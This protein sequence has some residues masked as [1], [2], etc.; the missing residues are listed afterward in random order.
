MAVI[1]ITDGG[2]IHRTDCVIW[3]P[4][5]LPIIRGYHT[6]VDCQSDLRRAGKEVTICPG[7][8]ASDAAC[9]A[10]RISDLRGALDALLAIP[11]D[12][13]DG[14]TDVRLALRKCRRVMGR[15]VVPEE[16]TC[17]S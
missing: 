17:R 7:C 10:S 8:L 1:V 6:L 13:D 16:A 5:H 9:M 2:T 14:N 12:L 3:Q 11:W 15:E 4:P